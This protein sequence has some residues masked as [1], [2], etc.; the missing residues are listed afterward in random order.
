M[1]SHSASALVSRPGMERIASQP[2]MAQPWPIAV[3]LVNANDHVAIHAFAGMDTRPGGEGNASEQL[4]TGAYLLP[5]TATTGA[6]KSRLRR[7]RI[8]S[9]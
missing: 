4:A 2:V 8:P 3:S 6:K 1:A 9:P 7:P 5:A